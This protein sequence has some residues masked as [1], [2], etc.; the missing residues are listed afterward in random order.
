MSLTLLGFECAVT[1][2]TARSADS[3]REEKSMLGGR[4]SE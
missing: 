2:D 4:L 3:A 1:E